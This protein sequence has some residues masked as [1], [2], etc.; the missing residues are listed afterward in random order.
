MLCVNRVDKMGL[1]AT[2]PVFGVSDKAS[3]KPVSSTLETILSKKRITRR[4]SDCA[5]AQAGLRLCCSQTPENRVSCVGAQ[6]K[7]TFVFNIQLWFIPLYFTVV[8]PSST[9]HL[10]ILHCLQLPVDVL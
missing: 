10:S 3:F 6:I 9:R 8:V 2:K 4:C 7:S 1:V 5:D